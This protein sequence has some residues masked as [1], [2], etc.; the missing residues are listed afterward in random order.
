MLRRFEM[1]SI[2]DGAPAAAVEKLRAALRDCSRFIPEVRHSAVGTNLSRAPLH[3]VWDH[4][5]ESAD[6]YR[7]YMVHPFHACV[8]DRYLLSDSPER[9]VSDNGLGAG[10]V[11]YACDAPVFY[12]G[13]GARRLVLLHVAEEAPDEAVRAVGQLVSDA[14]SSTGMCVSVF[15]ENTFASRWFDGVTP[16]A[17]RPSWTHL[18]EQGFESLHDMRSYLDGDSPSARA[19]RSGWVSVAGG[20]VQRS[21]DVSYEIQP[22]W[23]A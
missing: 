16:L 6:A 20:I 15:A 14:A 19:E 13:R 8:L 7:C 18:W 17:G 1:Y 12:L 9:I 2:R 4:A 3:L 10:L 11:G 23:R 5:Y 21:L 22:G